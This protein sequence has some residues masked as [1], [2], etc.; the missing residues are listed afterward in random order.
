MSLNFDLGVDGDDAVELVEASAEK[1][2][3]DIAPLDTEWDCYFLPEAPFF[4]P[5]G[6]SLSWAWRAITSFW[7][8]PPNPKL[9][10]PVSRL[11]ASARAG[12]WIS[13]PE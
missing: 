5:E 1:F 4:G 8:S 7:R 3:V 6:F 12:R 9:P 10:L 11:V 13:L 2:R